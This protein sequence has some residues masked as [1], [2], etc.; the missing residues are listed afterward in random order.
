[1]LPPV[2]LDTTTLD[3]PVAAAA[4]PRE[5]GA[6]A[7]PLPRWSL[8]TRLAFRF[9]VL[10][11]GLFVVSTQM[12]GGLLPFSWVR[13]LDSTAM[14]RGLITWT[15]M[16]VFHLPTAPSF[17]GTGSGDTM[18]DYL[19]VF[20]L[21]MAA[22]ATTAVW[23]ALDSRRANYRAL[24]KWFVV[25]LR[26]AVGST[27]VTYGMV[28]AI[29]LQMP[30]PGLQR[31]LEPFGNFSP[32]GVLWY[33]IGASKSYEMFA[34]FMEL[35]AGV[36]LFVPQL[37]MVGA[38]TTFGDTVQI[39]TLNM[40][41]D[42]PVKLFAFHLLLMSV[43]L[44]APEARRLANVLVFNR[45][46]APSTQLPLFRRRTAVL[47]MVAAQ[48]AYGGYIVWTNYARARQAWAQYGGGAPRS[49]LYGV[50]NIERMVIDG[51]ERAALISDY[52]RWRRVFF[53]SPASMTFQLMDETFLPFQAKVDTA[54]GTI[55]VAAGSNGPASALTFH[56]PDAEH[57]ILEGMLQGRQLRMETRRFDP[58]KFPLLNR[59]F[60]WIQE[61]PF[62]R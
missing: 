32:M 1:M 11:F 25:F 26:V 35:T 44:I 5:P 55:A 48:L 36:L 60:N 8:P 38:L 34:G 3:A 58:A 47:V 14:M 4:V 42:V 28:K 21:L 40:T 24:H 9:C 52:G 45:T 20:C 62:N 61:R 46:A 56:R 59:G 16:R 53:Q 27:M 37:A 10:Y 19:Q 29:P 17:E 33:S 49:P 30:A 22:G 2:M 54:A 23:S 13:S 18:A 15:G 51:Q 12:L 31:L 6:E 39:F 57:L 41:Y 7:A 43:V 50:W